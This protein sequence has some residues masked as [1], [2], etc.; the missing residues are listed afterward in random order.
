[1]SAAPRTARSP[2]ADPDPDRPGAWHAAGAALGPD[3]ETAQ[4]L[5]DA[6]RRARSRGAY[7]AAASSFERA[8]R[9]T[10][11]DAERAAP[12][13]SR[14]P[15]RPGSRATPSGHQQRLEEALELADDPALRSEIDQLRGHADAA[16]RAA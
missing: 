4:A 6:G 9:L 11:D 10:A 7:T 8:A 14:P 3:D 16:R 1:M 13:V 12:P 2:S 15:R 5:E